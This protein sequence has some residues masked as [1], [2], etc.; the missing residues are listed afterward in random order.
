MNERAEADIRAAGMGFQKLNLL[1]GLLGEPARD[2][3][4]EGCYAAISLLEVIEHLP[5]PPYLV[6]QKLRAHLRP[7]GVLLMTTPNGYRL[8]NIL[9]MLA[10]RRILDHFRHPGPDENMGHMHEYTLPQMLWQARRA[11]LEVVF[12]EHY[13]DG[14]AGSTPLRR[15]AKALMRALV[16]APHL[17]NGL[18]LGLRRPMAD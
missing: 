15:A 17:R 8:R 6:L 13:E 12:A 14:W 5:V 11:G 1:D 2:A 9:Y 4:G 16:L 18:V 3:P 7:G 10:N